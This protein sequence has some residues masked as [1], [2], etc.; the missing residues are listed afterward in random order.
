MVKARRGVDKMRLNDWEAALL[1]I[2]FVRVNP[3]NLLLL[4][5]DKD[6]KAMAALAASTE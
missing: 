1:S 3:S 4:V 6:I 2:V 5:F